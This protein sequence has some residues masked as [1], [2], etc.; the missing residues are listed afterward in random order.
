M[1]I[2]TYLW[3]Q[4]SDF[5]NFQPITQVYGIC[6]NEADE[7]LIIKKPDGDEWIL[8]GGKPE[9]GETFEEALIREAM[10]EAT[11][12]IKNCQPLGVQKVTFPQNPNRIEGD[13]FYQARLICEIDKVLP[14]TFDPDD[15]I[16]LDRK[17]VSKGEVTNWV[18]WG[19]EGAQMFA[20]AIEQV[21]SH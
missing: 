19:D 3:I 20:D 16:L 4:T 12:T 11:V 8:P 9:P 5:A 17:F 14:H 18:K 1:S 13:E 15:G 2:V 6:F 10:E 21:C 7:I